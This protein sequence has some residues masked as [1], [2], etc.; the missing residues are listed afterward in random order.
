VDIAKLCAAHGVEHVAV[1]HLAQLTGL[2]E[3][4]PAAG[5]RVLEVTTDRKRDAAWRKKLFAAA[6]AATS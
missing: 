5:I 1:G 6:A 4:L 3:V 2:L